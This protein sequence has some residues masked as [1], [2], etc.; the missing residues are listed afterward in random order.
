MSEQLKLRFAEIRRLMKEAEAQ[1]GSL[2]VHARLFRA[3]RDAA[4]VFMEIAE[5]AAKVVDASERQAHDGIPI[6]PDL[7]ATTITAREA[8]AR[9][10]GGEEAKAP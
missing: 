6:T 2:D 9:L 7:R 1:P 4:P 5:A 3:L 8:L 10:G